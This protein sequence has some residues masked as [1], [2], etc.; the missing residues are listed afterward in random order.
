MVLGKLNDW[1]GLQYY[2]GTA[3]T[4]GLL[5]ALRASRFIGNRIG[6]HVLCFD[7]E[8]RQKS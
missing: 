6:E 2:G 5:T 4:G 7:L 8:L 3:G 1:N